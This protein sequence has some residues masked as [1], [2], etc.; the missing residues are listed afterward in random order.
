MTVQAQF[1]DIKW[2]SSDTK[3]MLI[4]SL[5][6][7]FGVK[8]ETKKGSGGNDK[9]VVKGYKKDSITVTYSVNSSCGV[10]PE[11]ERTRAEGLLGK[12]GT[13]ILKDKRFGP[14]KTMLM[15][16][17]TSNAILSPTGLILSMD[18]TLS[19]GEPE[20]EK[21]KKTEKKKKNNKNKT[22]IAIN[23]KKVEEIKKAKGIK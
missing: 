10:S 6:Y 12:K 8:T 19:F 9:V 21:E 5:N 1:L 2:E 20:E 11:K 23:M 15:K 17:S 13:F 16:V 14:M 7:S 3:N 4:K 18:I 22:S